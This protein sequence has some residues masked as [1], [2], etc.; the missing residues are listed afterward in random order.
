[1]SAA[2]EQ[3]MLTALVTGASRGIGQAIA[4]QLAAQGM[5]VFGTATTAKGAQ[6]IDG[7]LG[8]KHGLVLRLDD[9]QSMDQALEAIEAQG[10]T[11]DVLV[12]NAGIT[13][14]QLLLRQRDEDWQTVIDTNLTGSVRLT[15][16]LL[17]GMVKQRFG[18]IV[19]LSS[20]VASIGNPGQTN[21]AAAKAGLEGFSRALALEVASR[22]IKQR[23]HLKDSIPSKRLGQPSDIAALVGFLSGGHAGYI[24]GQTIHVNGG[25]YLS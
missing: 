6:S 15:R 22:N 3:R 20:V 12:N 8:E 24:T 9:A 14:D 23:K 17:K 2:N 13:K 4:T 11:V 7:Y 10:Q 21:Y 5:H 1:M 16:A 19:H 18:R 25:M